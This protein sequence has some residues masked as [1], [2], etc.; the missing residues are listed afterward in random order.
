MNKAVV[1]D[2]LI[3]TIITLVAGVLLGLVHEVTLEP[4]AIANENIRQNAFR[5]VFTDAA[6]FEDM[7][8]FDSEEATSQIAADFPDDTIDGVEVALDDSGE[9]LGY[10]VTVTSSAGYGGNITLSIGIKNDGTLNGYSITSISETAGLGMKATEEKFSSQFNGKGESYYEVV[11]TEAASDAEIEAI[12]GA[13]I[14][15]RAVTYAVDAGIEY[16]N[17]VLSGGGAS[18]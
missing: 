4:I 9:I 11:K 13:T 3:L 17:T 1:K 7:E 10:V 12:S 16:F 15:S 14:T 6:S 8:N 18:E 2:A 5:E